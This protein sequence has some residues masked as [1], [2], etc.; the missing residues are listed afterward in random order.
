MPEPRPPTP[1]EPYVDRE[2]LR[3]LLAAAHQRLDDV[4]GLALAGLRFGAIAARRTADPAWLGPV[5]RAARAAADWDD[6]AA[7]T[8]AICG[9][10]T[11]IVERRAGLDPAILTLAH[12]TRPTIRAAVAR[13][14]PSFEPA[15]RELLLSMLHD[16]HGLV[17]GSARERLMAWAEPV[18]WWTG[19]VL[20]SPEEA[21]GPAGVEQLQAVEQHLRSYGRL[22]RP[23][24]DALRALPP[25]VVVPVLEGLLIAAGA[26]ALG[27]RELIAAVLETRGGLDML[28]RL[29]AGQSAQVLRTWAFWSEAAIIGGSDRARAARAFRLARRALSLPRVARAERRAG[30][31][32][33]VPSL[34]A[35]WAA[36]AWPESARPSRL[37]TLLAKVPVA[38]SDD[39][40][41]GTIASALAQ[42]TSPHA[43]ALGERMVRA[44]AEPD[45]VLI[46]Q[47]GGATTAQALAKLA[48]P[49]LR[50]RLALEALDAPEPEARARGLRVLIDDELGT[51]EDVPRLRA[52]LERLVRESPGGL[53]DYGLYVAHLIPYL[54]G[55][56]RAGELSEQEAASLLETIG[57]RAGGLWPPRGT[58]PPARPLD[59]GGEPGA[60]VGPPTAEEWAAYRAVR[61]AFFAEKPETIPVIWVAWGVLPAGGWAEADWGVLD[62]VVRAIEAGTVGHPPYVAECVAEV[63]R[64]EASPR[65]GALLRRLRALGLAAPEDGV[66]EVV[67]EREGEAARAGVDVE[68]W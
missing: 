13:G 46:A 63:L 37:L 56:L 7:A 9:A 44:L 19:L 32:D 31:I 57:T 33:D 20:E 48:P 51:E 52:A 49:E 29:W 10:I 3:T 58:K 8:R 1:R 42:A 35:R 50:R 2:Q 59:V 39:E 67:G 12:H 43:A 16:R 26:D 55:K 5:S 36:K 6:D 53:R 61:D 45:E 25:A 24:R 38:T 62:A 18:P 68:D 4:H 21:L 22:D 64:L 54:R 30:E 66:V 14:L 47:L 23:R 15:C 60:P 40:V 11:A 27:E 17:R 65:A 41:R 34:L 28:C